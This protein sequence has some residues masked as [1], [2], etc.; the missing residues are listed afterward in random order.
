MYVIQVV[1][2]HFQKSNRRGGVVEECSP[3]MREIG[4]RTM[5]GTDLSF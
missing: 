2:V 4:V 5:V 3:R 1:N